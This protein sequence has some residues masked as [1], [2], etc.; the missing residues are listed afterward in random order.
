MVLK[1]DIESA[2]ISQQSYLGINEQYID[3][4]YL[5]GFQ[6][7]ASHIEVI[8]GIRRCGKSTL[9][10]QIMHKYYSKIAF[11]N[12]EDSRIYNFEL[13]DFQKLDQIIGQNVDAYFFDEIQNV[14]SWE[15]FVR[16]LHDR[17]KKVFITGSNAS[18]LSKELGTRLTGRHL[19]HELFPFSYSEFLLFE[20]TL[21]SAEAFSSYL[22]NGGFPEFLSSG[23]PEILQNLLKDIVL[24]D[25]AVRYG[26]RNTHTLMD[27]TLFL[28]SNYHMLGRRFPIIVFEKVFQ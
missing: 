18:L 8:S 23:N 25:I 24:R 15:V 10:H 7:D 14:I 13:A 22:T 17:N 12:F 9:L 21:N 5:Q 26:I 2:Y 1:S 11:F 16:Q 4:S 6:P 20:K 19:K 28:I 3:R 27:I